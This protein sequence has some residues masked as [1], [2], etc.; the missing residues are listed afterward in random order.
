MQVQMNYPSTKGNNTALQSTIKLLQWTKI[1]ENNS[2]TLNVHDNPQ[3]D[4]AQLQTNRWSSRF[5]FNEM[6]Y[7]WTTITFPFLP[8]WITLQRGAMSILYMEQQGAWHHPS[9]FFSSSDWILD[10]VIWQISPRQPEIWSLNSDKDA[11]WC[12]RS[13]SWQQQQK[14]WKFNS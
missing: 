7:S 13:N 2:G 8:D 6:D 3:L 5:N 14:S 1:E 9:L 4:Q 10:S 11:S 12:K